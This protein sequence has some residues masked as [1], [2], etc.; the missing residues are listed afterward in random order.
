M[1]IKHL[2]TFKKVIEL[3]SLS[4]A[5]KALNI[6]QP[7]ISQHIQSL[8]SSIGEALLNRLP[9]GVSPTN[10]GKI[11][12]HHT[13]QIISQIDQLKLDFLHRQELTTGSLKFGIIPTLAPSLLPVI[14]R[15]YRETYTDLNIT[16]KEHRT[17][18]LVKLVQSGEIEFAILSD[19]T[20]KHRLTN[21][22]SQRTLF[23]E[24]L[25]LAVNK[26]HTLA[27][28]DKPINLS[29]VDPEELIYLTDGHCLNEQTLKMWQHCPSSQS[30]ICD[31]LQTAVSMV[32]VG[33]GIT[34]VPKLAIL[35]IDD[36]DLVIL[37]FK[38]K[39]IRRP[40]ILIS[41]QEKALSPAAK[42]FLNY[43]STLIK[44]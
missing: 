14:L 37:P 44:W 25:V 5:S 18:E 32:N 30:L 11:L 24:P 15:P 9:R 21:S 43:L 20:D 36:D 31:Q 26:N 29:D 40:I 27:T 6:S 7:A 10:A 42:I 28:S 19:L 23:H 2:V 38:E 33:M 8:E 4:A 1:Q 34:I 17:R 13:E 39:S 22:I 3:G 12:L 41:K 35:N 16:I